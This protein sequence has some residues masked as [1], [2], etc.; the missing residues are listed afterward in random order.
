MFLLPDK[1][2]FFMGKTA[3]LVLVVFFFLALSALRSS[4]WLPVVKAYISERPISGRA[5]ILPP[6]SDIYKPYPMPKPTRVFPLPLPTR[7]IPA[8]ATNKMILYSQ[9]S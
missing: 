3:K 7:Y 8:D 9:T 2:H 1:G 6:I 5:R 4:L